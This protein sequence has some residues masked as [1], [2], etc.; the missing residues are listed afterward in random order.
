MR[1]LGFSIAQLVLASV[2]AQMLE[3]S[4]SKALLISQGSP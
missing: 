2:L 4:L 1:K 3:P